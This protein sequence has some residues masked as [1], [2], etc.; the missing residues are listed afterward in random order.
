VTTLVDHLATLNA[1]AV[2]A[3]LERRPEVTA[4]TPPRNL[5][6]LARRLENAYDVSDTL[7]AA[8]LPVLQLAE[9]LQALGGR[10]STASLR[11]LLDAAPDEGE[12]PLEA[13][14]RWLEQRAIVLRSVDDAADEV[15]VGSPALASC[16]PSPL[17]LDPPLTVL[18]GQLDAP[19]LQR[20][21]RELGVRGPTR[22]A[23]VLDA[24]H[25]V[26]SD[27]E[28]VRAVAA[29]AP[30]GVRQ[31][32][33]LK[34]LPDDADPELID[35][36]RFRRSSDPAAYRRERQA[37]QWA[38]ARG[39]M[40]ITS[41]GGEQVP[42]EV[43]LALRGDDHHA[44][45]TPARPEVVTHAAAPEVVSR[46][47]AANAST[48]AGHATAL[49]DLLRRGPVALLQSGGVGARELKRLGKTLALEET[50][51]R[52]ALELLQDA[53]L[54]AATDDGVVPGEAMGSWRESEPA[55]QYAAL[56]AAW[57]RCRRVP[58]TSSER[59]RSAPALA[60]AGTNPGYPAARLALVSALAELPE[61]RG[62]RLGDLT[63]AVLWTRPLVHE[64]GDAAPFA[65]TWREAELL[66]VVAAG[67]LSA[68][69]HALLADD[70]QALL[71]RAREVLPAPT[72]R[73]LIGP[74][75]TAVVPGTPSARVT[76]GAGPVRRP[77]GPRGRGRLADHR[78]Q[79]APGAG[80]GDD[81]RGAAGAAGRGRRRRAAA[82]AG[83]P[84]GR[85]RP[86]ARLAAG[87]ARRLRG[88]Q[89]RRGAARAGRR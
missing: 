15:V 66:G 29:D 21:A 14:L 84:A 6:E 17:D 20:I 43:T 60:G 18:L 76:G 27:P 47:A 88:A 30:T 42:A 26:L 56:L 52:L 64:G 77:R 7:V 74:D 49:A 57:W 32:L 16:F 37:V 3:L 36:R 46:D 82:A 71:A 23:E 69:G 79:R 11:R 31:E 81:R 24:V 62:T 89:R 25:A 28:R 85:R 55:E 68:L 65:L 44:P 2:A 13:P 38:A 67:A 61:G 40:V 5:P 45:F 72:D 1:P 22:K 75:L 4:G 80:R 50:E 86:P 9:A 53:G 41:W 59:D 63:P 73:A 51:V 87:A 70:P 35:E 54:L 34:V 19:A 83:V 58:T 33:A 78:R 8:P 10:A 12:D 39:L 48:A